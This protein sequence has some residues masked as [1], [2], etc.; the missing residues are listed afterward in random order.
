MRTFACRAL[1]V[2]LATI[3]VAA[4]SSDPAPVDPPAPSTFSPSTRATPADA[5]TSYVALGDS[6]TAGPGIAPQQPDSGYCQ[7]SARNWPTL[8]AERLDI[9]DLTDISCSGATSSD[10]LSAVERA[11]LDEGTDLVTLGVG[12]NDGALFASLLSACAIEG[13]ECG[14]FV[15]ERTRPILE[16]TVDGVARAV[17]AIRERAPGAQVLLVGYLP[18]MPAAGTCETLGVPASQAPRVAS[19]ERALEVALETAADE[20]GV[21]LVSLR[22]ASRGHDA[23]RGDAAWTNGGTDGGSD[24]IVYHPNEAGMRGVAATVADALG[25]RVSWSGAR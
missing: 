18:I 1:A 17:D 19:A 15:A 6:F 16:R 4:C 14:T 3:I 8:L 5:P 25:G 9:D 10:V 11:P 20:S 22:R 24:G 21:E 12:G 23:C 13:P 2:V 7:R